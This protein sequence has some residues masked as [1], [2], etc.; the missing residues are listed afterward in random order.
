MTKVEALKHLYE[1]LG[2][3]PSDVLSETQIANMID[4]LCDVAGGGGGDSL[5]VHNITFSGDLTDD[6]DF[7][8][9]LTITVKCQIINKTQTAFNL[10]SFIAKVAE[11]GFIPYTAVDSSGDF[12]LSG[13]CV[14]GSASE[15]YLNAFGGSVGT[16]SV[17]AGVA[18]FSEISS[19]TDSVI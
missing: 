3:N 18:Y 1:T 19:F 12:V 16:H 10:Q 11:D 15:V 5:Y 17:Q 2:G 13:G 4:K 7:L 6:F 9:G 8:D 14:R